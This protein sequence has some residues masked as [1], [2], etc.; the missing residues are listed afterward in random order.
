M[1]AAK[2]YTTR[3]TNLSPK[4]PFVL[5]RRISAKCRPDLSFKEKND[6]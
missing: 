2:V 4:K 6:V 1:K 5:T 3:T